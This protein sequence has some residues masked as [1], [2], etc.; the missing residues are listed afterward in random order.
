MLG[1]MHNKLS[2]GVKPLES[3]QT[4]HCRV[5]IKELKSILTG[6]HDIHLST[7]VWWITLDGTQSSSVQSACE[8]S[9]HG[10]NRSE[11]SVLEPH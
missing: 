2:L 1:F 5:D 6:P 10:I 7:M 8:M 11:F 3:N 4:P 9:H